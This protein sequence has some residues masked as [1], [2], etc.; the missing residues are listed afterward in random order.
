MPKPPSNSSSGIFIRLLLPVL[1][2]AFLFL[3]LMDSLFGFAPEIELNEKRKLTPLPELS[4]H[5]NSFAAF[6]ERFEK[7]YDDNF[8]FRNFL[9][10]WHN[11]IKMFW[12]GASPTSNIILGKDGWLF[13]GEEAARISYQRLIALSEADCTAWTRSL[14]LIREW[15]SE[16][17][18]PFVVMVP[19]N[20]STVYGEYMPDSIR[21]REVPPLIDQFIGCA[22]EAGVEV[23]D[24]RD[25][26]L[27]AKEELQLYPRTDTHWTPAGAHLGYRKL[28]VTLN[29][30]FP[31]LFNG[32]HSLIRLGEEEEYTGDL[33]VMAGLENISEK[34]PRVLVEGELG[35]PKVTEG[36]VGFGRHFTMETR[37]EDLPRAVLFRDSYGVEFIPFLAPHFRRLRTLWDYRFNTAVIEEEDPDIVFLEI[38]ERYLSH[39][40]EA[41]GK[42]SALTAEIQ[43][44]HA[45]SDLYKKVGANEPD[46]SSVF[47]TV[48]SAREGVTPGGWLVFG[49]YRWLASG[50]Y[51]VTFRM[52]AG[53]GEA[54]PLARIEVIADKGERH[55]ARR[56]VFLKDFGE[57]PSWTDFDLVFALLE[58]AHDIEFRIE[59]FGKGDLDVDTVRLRGDAFP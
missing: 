53:G 38:I 50:A 19:P 29:A 49:P 20:K 22:G 59:Y 17:G 24:F 41:L 15:L 21:S 23:L 36:I 10:F 18:I 26:F 8:G 57:T 47:G 54:G 1:F 39:G 6:P 44:I 28:M 31:A 40:P 16:R 52:R 37:R 5:G 45:A 32:D 14:R 4:G 3:P 2:L 27:E 48:R 58:E 13:F 42:Y 34:L 46:G 30:R 33:A 12:F 9:A 56:T 51:G 55:L 25:E 43:G 35:I 7:Y 11:Y